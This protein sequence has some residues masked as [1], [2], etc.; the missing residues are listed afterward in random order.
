MPM[1]QSDLYPT[2]RQSLEALVYEMRRL[3]DLVTLLLEYIDPEAAAL[4][5]QAQ[6]LREHNEAQR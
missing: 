2:S 6:K 1:T 4:Y 3:N 5:A